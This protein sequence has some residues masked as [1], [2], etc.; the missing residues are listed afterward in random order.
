MMKIRAQQAAALFGV[1]L[2]A[3][4]ASADGAQ[5]LPREDAIAFCIE[6]REWVADK[7][8]NE[9][10][11]LL[12]ERVPPD[13]RARVRE[14]AMQEIK[15]GGTG[16]LEPRQKARAAELDKGRQLAQI[17]TYAGREAIRACQQQTDCKTALACGQR[18][19]FGKSNGR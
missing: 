10:A 18:V 6:Q 13:K 11:D 4:V 16:P 2:P 5:P 1:V 3:L 8:A 17:S 12:T 15:E 14:K 7:C 19:M 9:F